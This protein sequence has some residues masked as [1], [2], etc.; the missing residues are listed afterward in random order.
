MLTAV[1]FDALRRREFARLDEAGE[2]YLDYTGSG[3]PAASLVAA[4]HRQLDRAILG[5]P[6]SAHA[7]SRRST[8]M[9]A[10]ARAAVLEFFGVSASTHA[11]CFAANASAASKLVA[12]S[13]PFGSSCGLV[14]TS[15]NHNSV[16]GL[17]EFAR[18]ASAPVRYVPL[19]DDLRLADPLEHLRA[20]AREGGGLFAL[21]AQSNFSGVEHPLSLV[22]DARALGFDVLLDAA[23]FVPTHS[24]DLAV[25]SAD[26]VV[27][28]FYKMF[29]YPTGV[30]ALIARRDAL[31]R[32]SRPWFAG[33][34]VD[35]V[36][37]QNDRHT[38]RDGE[39]A[40]EDGTPNF[41]AI[42]AV[43]AGL[44]LLRG[45]GMQ[46]IHARV[47]ELTAKFLGALQ[48]LQ[49]PNGAPL[50]AIYGPHDACR[51]GGTVAFNILDSSGR[52]QPYESIEIDLSDRKIFVRGGCFCN[53]GAAEAAFHFDAKAEA[54]CLSSLGRRFTVSRFAEC[55][56]PNVA[57]GA[58]R[59]SIGVPTTE[60]D[61]TR[62]VETLLEITR[63]P[64]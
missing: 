64:R 27:I 57:V 38:L 30:G 40:F 39:E 24:L 55:L 17:R 16:N 10:D 26:F 43:P 44:D 13:Y 52:V 54:R 23:A 8:A 50:V 42:G 7:A 34:T 2:I 58:L 22:E 9:I 12:E 33:G 45:I 6:H 63:Y 62:A 29:G 37:V 35:V 56:G 53:P 25:C 18:R 60:T 28:S 47:R 11:V 20:S 31:A 36:S 59:A 32:L 15:D 19:D 4:H 21:P 1:D 46:T 5:N 14:L 3:I 61:L 49:R 48:E 41:A 51:R